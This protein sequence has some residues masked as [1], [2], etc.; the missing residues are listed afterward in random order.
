AARGARGAAGGVRR[1]RA[2]V[3]RHAAGGDAGRGGQSERLAGDP[4]HAGGAPAPPRVPERRLATGRGAPHH[5]AGRRPGALEASVS[6]PGTAIRLERLGERSIG[7][8]GGPHRSPGRRVSERGRSEEAGPPTKLNAMT[9]ATPTPRKIHPQAI[10]ARRNRRLLLVA[11]ALAA[12]A[13]AYG[14]SW[15]THD[16]FWVRTDNAYVTGNL[17]PVAAQASGIVTQ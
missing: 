11:L 4:R 7:G 12:A 13:A 9:V 8:R 6:G 16:R 17:I 10:R 15:W 5:R 14:W 2:P 3:Q 1:R